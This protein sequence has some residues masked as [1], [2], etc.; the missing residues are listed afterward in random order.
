MLRDNRLDWELCFRFHERIS[1]AR[2]DFQLLLG[3]DQQSTIQEQQ[4]QSST[5]RVGFTSLRQ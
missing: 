3:T 2:C 1:L 4:K 5:V